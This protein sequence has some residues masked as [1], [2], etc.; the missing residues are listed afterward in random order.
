M[1]NGGR[2]GIVAKT[3][4]TGKPINTKWKLQILGARFH[5]SDEFLLSKRCRYKFPK[6][7]LN[8]INDKSIDKNIQSV[9]FASLYFI[10]NSLLSNTIKAVTNRNIDLG[11]EKNNANYFW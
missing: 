2:I 6:S 1:N 4:A 8:V 11:S 5:V 10:M 3:R 7:F 9:F